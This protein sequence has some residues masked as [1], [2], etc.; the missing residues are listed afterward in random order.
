[1]RF[2]ASSAFTNPKLNNRGFTYLLAL[3]MVMVMGIM[4]GAA[5]QSWK[6][7]MHREREEELLFRGTQIR[8][9]IARWYA[10]RG[11]EQAA[12][13]LR[14]LRDLLSDP[15]SATPVRYLRRLYPD[16]VTGKEWTVISDPNQGIIGVASTSPLAPLKVDN[17]PD[18]LKD[19][20]GKQR[21]S[22]WK[23][24]YVKKQ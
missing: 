14:D 17:F 9:A 11:T 7:V 16:P 2:C 1:M 8:N 23:F 4:L 10:P 5:G 15:R 6:T 3:M 13:P 22:D 24:V 21:Y 19:C 18:D 12:T 20:A